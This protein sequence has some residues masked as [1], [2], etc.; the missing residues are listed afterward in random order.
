MRVTTEN[1]SRSYT[2]DNTGSNDVSDELQAIFDELSNDGINSLTFEFLPGVYYINKP[3][4]LKFISVKIIGDAHGGVD[5]H[6]MNLKSGTVFHFGK[7]CAPNCITFHPN[8]DSASFPSGTTPWEYKTTRVSLSHINFMGYNNTDV[9]TQKGYS[10]FRGDLPNFRGLFWYPT[11]DRYDDIEKEGQRA[12][13]IE[14]SNPNEKPEM[15]SV[16]GCYFTDL[17]VGLE[18]FNCD[19]S[20]IHHSWFGQ[21]VYGIRYHHA[22]QCIMMH[23]NCFADLET[24]IQLHEPTMSTIHNNALAYVSKCF[25]VENASEVNIS[26]NVVKNWEAATGTASCGAFIYAKNSQ[27][28]NV[29]NNT[30]RHALDSR[31]KTR[32]VDIESN[33]RHFVHFDGCENL[34]ITGNILDT[35]QTNEVICLKNCKTVCIKTNIITD[36]NKNNNNILSIDCV[37]MQT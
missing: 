36:C 17:Y 6:G 15:L 29:N 13:V 7:N 23:D 21:M 2:L 10:R 5:I 27:N 26:S 19:V 20:N 33:G 28:L 22:G 16:D 35:K 37:D 30:V 12:I 32:T 1:W 14:Q 3:L 8:S 9:D 11:K 4:N 34:M 24:A 31:V 18:I 25:I